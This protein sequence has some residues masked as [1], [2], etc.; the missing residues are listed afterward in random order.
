MRAAVLTR[1]GHVVIEE[2]LSPSPAPARCGCGS[3]CCGV[4]ASNLAPWSGPDWMSFPWSRARSAMKAGAWSTH[5]AKASRASRIGT[6]VA[7]LS[8]K[9]YAQYD[10]AAADA[11]VPLPPVLA[12]KAFPGEPFGC[13]MNIF[14]RSE[15]AAGQTVAILGIG[16]LGAILTRLASDAGARVIAI[17]RR[18]FSLEVA[19][20]MGAA[21]TLP[22][23]DHHQIIAR[24]EGDHRR[25]DVRARH[26]GGRQAMAAGPRRRSSLPSAGGS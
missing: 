3:K 26:R 12:G 1:P 7:A 25:R 18:P 22:M 21:E 6:P 14:R 16:F 4:C 8:Y 9:A 20:K 19:R 15:I 13:A 2:F 23:E 5:S 11:V 24:G 17:S 10:I